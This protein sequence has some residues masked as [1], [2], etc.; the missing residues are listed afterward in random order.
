MDVAQLVK[1]LSTKHKFLS[2]N[3]STVK[4]KNER[5]EKKLI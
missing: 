3:P 1:H 4:K 2:S 5:R